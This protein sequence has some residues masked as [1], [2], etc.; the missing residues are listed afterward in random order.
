MLAAFLFFYEGIQK[1]YNTEFQTRSMQSL[2]VRVDLK[3]ESQN[4]TSKFQL[5]L[6]ELHNK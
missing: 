4:N 5:P 1:V 2:N 6:Q 3:K